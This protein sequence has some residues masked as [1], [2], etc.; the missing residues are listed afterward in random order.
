MTALRPSSPLL[1]FGIASKSRRSAQNAF[2]NPA[3]RVA[4]QDEGCTRPSPNQAKSTSARRESR[5]TK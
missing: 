2:V 5:K 1:T 4:I 3:E